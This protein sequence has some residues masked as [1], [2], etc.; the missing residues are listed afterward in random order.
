MDAMG[1]LKSKL[2]QAQ[3][4]LIGKASKVMGGKIVAKHYDST[5]IGGMNL[6]KPSPIKDFM[7]SPM[8]LNLKPRMFTAKELK[9]GSKNPSTAMEHVE[10]FTDVPEAVEFINI[11]RD[12]SSVSTTYDNYVIGFSKH[13]R[14]DKRFHPSYFLFVGNRDSGD[15]GA[16]TGRLSVHDPAW[17]TIP[18]HT[19][20]AKDIR[21]C[22][23]APPGY[24]VLER[25]YSQGELRVIACIADEKNMIAAY[26]AGMDL[27][28]KTS[29][30]FSKH[31][32]ES[33]AAL[34]KTDLHRYEEIRQLGR[35]YSG[36][37][38][39][40]TQ[41]GW[42]R[43]DQL[44]QGVEVLQY[45]PNGALSFVKP[46][47]YHQYQS[48]ELWH[49]HDRHTDL[50]ITPNHVQ[51]LI[52]RYERMV[53]DEIGK[54]PDWRLNGN[55]AIHAGQYTASASLSEITTRLCVMIQ[56]D[57]H[58]T[59]DGRLELGFSKRR[60]IDRA[61]MLLASAGFGYNDEDFLKGEGRRFRVSRATLAASGL[62]KRYHKRNLHHTSCCCVIVRLPW[63]RSGFGI[64]V[65]S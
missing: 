59:A 43:L 56:A 21:R 30:R 2:E 33:L 48:Q 10:M 45:E 47:A 49:L 3:V 29:A 46:L 31:T 65:T 58:Y 63:M 34:E 52:D 54:Y 7:F 28:V 20:W 38:E 57:G 17:Q 42:V 16:V 50:M 6:T 22:Y 12:Y 64:P 32:Y 25:D 15:G 37:T 9:D 26:K 19:V 35:C 13:I 36:D 1:A 41:Q 5:K 53:L 23:P 24:V 60:K 14:P 27:H 11:Q 55:Y 8:G 40:I 51:P 62:I 18:K 4:E 44:P 61:R 39:V